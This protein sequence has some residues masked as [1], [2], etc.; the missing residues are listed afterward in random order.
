MTQLDDDEDSAMEEESR[1]MTPDPVDARVEIVKEWLVNADPEHR[2]PD[3]FEWAALFVALNAAALPEPVEGRLTEKQLDEIAHRFPMLNA[4]HYDEALQE[5]FRYG[6]RARVTTP[7]P[8]TSEQREAIG[9]VDFDELT[10]VAEAEFT[11]VYDGPGSDRRAMRATVE[12]VVC[13]LLALASRG[14][15]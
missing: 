6:L 14:T 9:W 10:D 1:A 4:E 5:A 2:N 3:V 11:N 13:F 15:E 8:L 12:R 7:H